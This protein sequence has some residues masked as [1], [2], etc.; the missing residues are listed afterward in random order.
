[1]AIQLHG[2]GGLSDDFPLA[3][4]WTGARSLRLADGPDEVHRG[5]GRPPRARQVPAERGDRRRRRP[6]GCWSPAR[7]PG[8]GRG[9]GRG[10]RARGDEVLRDRRAVRPATDLDASTSP[11]TTTGPPRSR[12]G[13]GAA[14]AGST[15]WSTTPVSPAAAGST[16]PASTSGS[17]SSRSTCSAWSAAAA[18]SSRCSSASARARIVNVAS[19][20][21][22]VHPA[23]MASYNAVKAGVVALTETARPRALAVR[24]ERAAWSARR[25]S[26]PT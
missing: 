18:P 15:C 6:R 25:T 9:A 14:G 7:R 1:M 8:L 17:G 22:L 3:A 20:A 4:A 21:G 2:G 12:L 11:P 24:R 10:V 5:D 16:W 13:R 19:L 23:G 26:G